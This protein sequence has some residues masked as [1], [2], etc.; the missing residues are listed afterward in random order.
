LTG[1]P[2]LTRPLRRLGFFCCFL[3]LLFELLF[4]LIPLLGL[5]VGALLALHFELFFRAQQ[6]DERLFGAVALLEAGANDPQIAAVAVAVAR[7]HDIKEPLD[8]I[9]GAEEGV[10]LAARVQIALLARVIIFSTCGR[11]ALALATV[12][13]TRSSS[14]TD[15]VRLRKSALR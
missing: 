2:L 5:Q 12:V 13:S 4:E 7:S 15:V 14:I 1:L 6:F 3:L 11:T 8:G 9:V 10:R